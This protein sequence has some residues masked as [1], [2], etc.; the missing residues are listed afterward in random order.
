MTRKEFIKPEAEGVSKRSEL[1]PCPC[2][3]NHSKAHV[4]FYGYAVE[5][6]CGWSGPV[7]PTR[8]LAIEAWN[9]RK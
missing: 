6:L 3:K 8:E 4:R 9:E 1:K 5:S 2:G 7:K